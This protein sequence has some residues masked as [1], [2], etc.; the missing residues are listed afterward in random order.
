MAVIG[1]LPASRATPSR[2]PGSS[3]PSPV[4]PRGTEAERRGSA[5]RGARGRARG[6][7]RRRVLLAVVRTRRSRRPGL[8]GEVMLSVAGGR[9]ILTLRLHGRRSRSSR[10]VISPPL[11]RWRSGLAILAAASSAYPRSVPRELEEQLLVDLLA[12]IGGRR[13]MPAPSLIR[14]RSPASAL[15]DSVGHDSSSLAALP[16]PGWD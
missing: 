2:S 7:P 5:R 9:R 8:S 10:R 11:R 15:A 14:L 4:I 1:L 3:G 13:R 16:A 12:S 6:H